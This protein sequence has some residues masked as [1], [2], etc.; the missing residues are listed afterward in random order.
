MV[1]SGIIDYE[2]SLIPNYDRFSKIQTLYQVARE[3]ISLHKDVEVLALKFQDD[4]IK[5]L[6]GLHLA[7]AEEHKV[8]V[9]LTTDDVLIRKANKLDI[10]INVANPASW[11]LEVIQSEK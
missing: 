2:L 5:P 3:R 8:D 1:S 7:I 9:F 10:K 4:G 6:D 11:Y